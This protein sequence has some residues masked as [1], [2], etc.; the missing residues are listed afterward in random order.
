MSQKS[1]CH[2]RNTDDDAHDHNHGQG[3][4]R[5]DLIMH[6][7]LA[8]IVI[9]LALYGLGIDWTSNTHF[10]RALLD[11]FKDMWWGLAL[12]LISVGLMNKIPKEYFTAL[13]GRGDKFSDIIKAAFAGVVLD[14]C[15]HG[16]LVVAAKLYER[17]LS[18][19]QVLTFLIASPWNSLS[20]TLILIALVGL[21]WTIVFTL[22]SVV[23]AI[24]SGVIFQMLTEKGKLPANPHTADVIEDFDVIADAKVR[25]KGF[26]FTKDWFTSVAKDSW[27]DGQMIIRW[28]LF[29]TVAAAAIH[30]FV[31]SDILAQYFGPTLIGLFLTLIVSTIIEICSEGSAP[32]AA[33]IMNSAAAPGN[34]FTFLMS[35]VATDYTEILVVREF[36]KSWKIALALPLITVP[37]IL[38][39][40][41]IFNQ[42]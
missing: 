7:S 17:G 29:G 2:S 36:T 23:I 34:A 35:G 6:G 4:F 14:L 10:A 28:I 37:Q 41:Y 1:C 40:G 8:I 42:F 9:S 13:L 22:A 12:G 26:T 31:P 5:P 3:G 18:S 15:N 11:F 20:I 25:L 24:A 32:I 19:A 30:T 38:V 39:L 33:E 27:T 21:K 16:I